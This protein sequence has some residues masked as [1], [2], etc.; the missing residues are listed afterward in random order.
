MT[1]KSKIIIFVVVGTILFVLFLGVELYFVRL[2][3]TR[4]GNERKAFMMRAIKIDIGETDSGLEENSFSNIL[5]REL[6]SDEINSQ[7]E[8]FSHNLNIILSNAGVILGEFLPDG[9]WRMDEDSIC[10][11]IMNEERERFIFRLNNT[12]VLNEYRKYT[13]NSYY[14]YDKWKMLERYKYYVMVLDSFYVDDIRLIPK[15]ISI[16]EAKCNF[17]EDMKPEDEDKVSVLLVDTIE[18]NDG[19]ISGLDYYEIIEEIDSYSVDEYRFQYTRNGKEGYSVGTAVFTE[20][21]NS[22]KER[23]EILE[24]CLNETYEFQ[25]RDLVGISKYYF[26]KE[27]YFSEY[28]NDYVTLVGCEDN[29]FY[30]TYKSLWQYVLLILALDAIVAYGIAA[31]VFV[32]KKRSIRK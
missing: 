19:N 4:T 12:D 5:N 8:L 27:K 26:A 24:D 21:I 20:K 14:Y 15:K 30:D 28:Y 23:K 31:P 16:Y 7:S 29:I 32:I 6:T 3:D 13:E 22:V 11:D 18:F 25:E 2:F 9:K 10:I 1:K 17:D